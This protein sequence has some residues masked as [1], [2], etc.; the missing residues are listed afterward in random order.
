MHS[1]REN[2]MNGVR[3]TCNGVSGLP[4]PFCK[5]GGI[6]RCVSGESLRQCA[7]LGVHSFLE[8][9]KHRSDPGFAWMHTDKPRSRICP[10]PSGTTGAICGGSESFGCRP[11]LARSESELHGASASA[12]TYVADQSVANKTSPQSNENVAVIVAVMVFSRE[13]VS[14]LPSQLVAPE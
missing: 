10:I 5:C 14:L 1:P 8:A 3:P 12:L 13:V 2:G 7:R 9:R 6:P 11:A 4:V